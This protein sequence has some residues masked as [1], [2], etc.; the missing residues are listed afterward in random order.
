MEY[1]GQ[2]C[3]A[4]RRVIVHRSV[5]SAFIPRLVEA[6]EA[7]RVGMP[8]DEGT[9]IGPV[10]NKAAKQSVVAALDATRLR[11]AVTL[12]GAGRDAG[13]G[14]FVSPTLVQVADPTDPFTQKETFG[15]AAAILVASSA[16]EAVKVANATPFGLSGAVFGRDIA[17]AR[18]VA[19]RLDTGLQRVNAPTTG[20]DFHVPFGGEKASGYGP[21]EQGRAAKEFFT[22]TRTM[23][24]HAPR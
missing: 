12:T 22:R 9:E 24:V 3:T 11:G 17:S 20:A 8:E 23:L 2:K 6:V 16:D 7:M 5:A 10:I 15:P 19:A 13:E 21:H 14:W 1:A 4:T 18:S